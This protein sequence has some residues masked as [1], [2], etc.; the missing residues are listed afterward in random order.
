MTAYSRRTTK[1]TNAV[2]ELMKEMCHATNAELA[3]ELRRH[4]PDV[5]DTTVHRVTSRLYDDGELTT[6]PS[7]DD[8]AVRYDINIAQHDHFVCEVCGSLK[9]IE[10]PDRCRELIARQLEGCLVNGQLMVTGR[11]LQCCEYGKY[12]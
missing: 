5:S 6:G 4:F 12:A 10:V 11:C 8:G 9:D 1:Y 7:T 2:R 3:E